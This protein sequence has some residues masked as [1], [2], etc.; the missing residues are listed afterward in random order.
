MDKKG[1]SIRSNDDFLRYRRGEM[2][3]AER[4]VFER[5]LQ[6]DPFA[7]EA[8]EGFSI[9][10]AEEA[11]GDLKR[12]AESLT[13]RSRKSSQAIYYRI[14]AAAAVLVTLSVVFFSRN[15]ET[16]VILS[17]NDLEK[18]ETT[19]FIAA[20]EPLINKSKNLKYQPQ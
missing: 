19:L 6:K 16:E 11:E 3:P 9:L 17:K 12:I 7:E 4:N 13:M 20:S 5:D 14:A 2:T 10:S 8:A 15:R 1:N 18:P